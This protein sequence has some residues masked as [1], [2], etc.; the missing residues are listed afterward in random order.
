MPTLPPVLDL[1]PTPLL[2]QP[3]EPR[4]ERPPPRMVVD[5]GGIDT[6]RVAYF[7]RLEVGLKGVPE[8][9]WRWSRRK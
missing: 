5:D 1:P 4:L 9:Y 2:R 7:E 6:H 8:K 3:R